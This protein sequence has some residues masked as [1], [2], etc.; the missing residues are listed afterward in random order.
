MS[1]NALHKAAKAG[2]LV[3]V[4]LQV[5]NFDINAKGG[6]SDMTALVYA[7]YFG[8]VEV[9][10]LLLTFNPDVNIPTVSTLT[11]ISVHLI[12]IF[13][14]HISIPHPPLYISHHV[15]LSRVVNIPPSTNTM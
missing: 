13:S 15:L 10:K 14:S 5:G 8:H 6:S 7:V 1:D 4:Q 11:I 12:C 9:V 2:N 3:E